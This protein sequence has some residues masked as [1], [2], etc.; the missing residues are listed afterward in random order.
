VKDDV[1]GREM[2]LAGDLDPDDLPGSPVLF[3]T[4]VSWKLKVALEALRYETV[5]A[6]I[7]PQLEGQ[8][9]IRAERYWFEIVIDDPRWKRNPEEDLIF[10][11]ARAR[12]VMAFSNDLSLIKDAVFLGQAGGGAQSVRAHGGYG[13]SLAYTSQGREVAAWFDM[14]RMNDAHGFAKQVEVDPNAPRGMEDL[15]FEL[16]PPRIQYD[17][18]V[19]LEMGEANRIRLSLLLGETR[20]LT[21]RY[22]YLKSFY[23]GT[24]FEHGD[25]LRD[26]GKYAP[27]DRAIALA[28]LAIEPRDFFRV[29]FAYLEQSQREL[30]EDELKK[31][32]L[33]PQALASDLGS[34]LEGPICM[35]LSRMNEKVDGL[36]LDDLE[37]GG[38]VNPRAALLLTMRF[39]DETRIPLFIDYIAE[40]TPAELLKMKRRP[41]TP[42]GLPD[43][44]LYSM[45]LTHA[46][47]TD[48]LLVPA[49][50]IQG[51]RFYFATNEQELLRALRAAE[52]APRGTLAEDPD[53]LE[54]VAEGPIDGGLL[55][56]AKGDMLRKFLL[57]QRHEQGYVAAE[58][59]VDNPNKQLQVRGD[60]MR[61][62]GRG[63]SF[64]N[65]LKQEID[66]RIE[67]WKE[68]NRPIEFE[69]GL[70][71]WRR[72]VE[73]FEPVEAILLSI[74]PTAKE[75]DGRVVLMTR[76]K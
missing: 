56:L 35:V 65:E 27:K 62:L 61:E 19:S 70:E 20:E 1:F 76:Q 75:T 42:E 49:M 52:S 74:R 18:S 64:T 30:L 14:L 72:A 4:R 34:Y 21:R 7:E 67:A 16:I 12:D 58:A 39:V 59:V 66:R 23:D 29:L 25:V 6:K 31:A 45:P 54:L 63:R 53:L 24:W 38:D 60:L 5:R 55:V 17:A 11:L 36:P 22:E 69:K 51:N 33:T 37:D 15:F 71:A 47:E 10:Y 9:R 26:L 57:D 13:R 44:K 8:M 68:Q 73:N 28:A 32:A 3:L 46:E 48:P 2:L 40:Q 41:T 43:V 50:A